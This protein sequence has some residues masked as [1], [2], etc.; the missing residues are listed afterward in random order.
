MAEAGDTVPRPTRSAVSAVRHGFRSA[1]G[2]K[3]VE[4]VALALLAIGCLLRALHFLGGRSLWLDEAMVAD[5]I[6]HRDWAGLLAPLSYS[7]VAPLGWLMVERASFLLLGG[8]DMALRAPALLAGLASLLLFAGAARRSFESYGYLIA[9]ATFAVSDVLV[10]YSAEVKPYGFDALVAVAALAFA[11]H[12]LPEDKPLRTRDYIVLLLAGLASVFVSFPAAFILA[13]LGGALFLRDVFKRRW[14]HALGIAAVSSVWLL[15]F[16][17]LLL[18]LRQSASDN[19]AEM[20]SSW[21][22]AYAP[23]QPSGLGELKWYARA[24]MDALEYMFGQE[25]MIAWAVAIA[26]GAVLTIRSKFYLAVALL[27]PLAGALVAS[28]F[29]LYPFSGRLL[30]FA[31][32]A[33]MFLAVVGVQAAVSAFKSPLAGSLIA[34]LLLLYGPA[35]RLWGAFTYYPAPFATE[36]VLPVMQTMSGHADVDAVFVNLAGLPAYRHYQQ[37]AGLA[38]LTVIES[39][40]SR[41]SLGCLLADMEIV[42]RHHRVWVFYSHAGR[43]VGDTPEDVVFTQIADA[44]GRRLQSIDLISVHAY[45]YE[46]DEASAQSISALRN[47]TSVAG[48]CNARSPSGVE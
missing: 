25:S 47:A 26:I 35:H 14:T 38:D 48:A 24:V 33:L 18:R 40:G 32:P 27:T 22:G 1:L 7:Q 36:H 19:V 2:N 42:S 39:T 23:I 10:F 3:P 12:Y 29:Q 37:R 16:A 41:T 45:L 31:A 4:R 46:F 43:V 44:T 15:A 6:V 9:I 21:A 34:V 11:A 30:L 5:S 13:G 8:S 28:G 20:T 17:W